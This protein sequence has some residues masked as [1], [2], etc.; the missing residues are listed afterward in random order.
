LDINLP[1]TI[2]FLWLQGIDEVPFVAKKCY[3]SWIIKNPDWK[4]IF[5]DEKNLQ[6]YVDA[7]KPGN[8]TNQAWSDI[9]RINLLAEYGGVWVDAT[10][11]CVKPL[12][13][14]LPDVI[15]TGFFAFER[16]G[17]DRM[18]SSWFI[19][20]AKDNYIIS[21]YRNMVNSYWHENPGLI[22]A[23]SATPK[24]LKRKLE[25]M[26]T[27]KWFAWPTR[28]VLKLYPYFWFHYLFETLYL[29]DHRFRK[30]WDLTPKI[31]SDIP[32]RLQFAGLFN[33]LTNEI[34]NEIGQQASPLYKLTWKYEPSEDEKDTLMRY[35][36]ENK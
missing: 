28:K 26:H 8:A 11:F 4:V 25:H 18:I 30:L 15:P 7:S 12:D 31:S 33:P 19:A 14:W 13:E 29:H 9:I 27:Q 2:W 1:K 5:L 20:A 3:E 23:E 21:A 16:P 32:H 10:C 35:L 36:L 22:S 17:P 24:L 34:K 6:Q